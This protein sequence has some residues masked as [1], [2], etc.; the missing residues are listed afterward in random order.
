MNGPTPI[1]ILS[2]ARH[3]YFPSGLCFSGRVRNVLNDILKGCMNFRSKGFRGQYLR[4][5]LGGEQPV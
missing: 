5:S 1:F 2:A 4:L 3:K